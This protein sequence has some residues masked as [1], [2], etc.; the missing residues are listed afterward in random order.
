[1]IRNVNKFARKVEYLSSVAVSNLFATFNTETQ[2]IVDVDRAWIENGNYYTFHN[3]SDSDTY[4]RKVDLRYVDV[5]ETDL[6]D[7]LTE[8]GFKL[9]GQRYDGFRMLKRWAKW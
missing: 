4:L 5:C 2:S 8:Y 1:M 7:D 3:S 9:L 6:D